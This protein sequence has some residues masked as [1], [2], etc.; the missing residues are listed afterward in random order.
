M[1]TGTTRICGIMADPVEHSMSPVM[2]NFYGKV[3]GKDFAYIPMK[4]KEEQVEAAIKG[5]YAMNFLG[6]NVTV[7]HKQ[8][9]IKY[10]KEIDKT[11]EMIG[12]VNTLVRTDGGF[13]G[14]NADAAGLYRSMEEKGFPLEGASCI[15][16]GAGGAARAAACVFMEHGAGEVFI[17]NRNRTRG[18]ELA[19]DMN[20]LAGRKVFTA[21]GL[22]DYGKIPEGKYICIQSTSVGMHPHD[23]EALIEDKSFYDKISYGMDVVYTP[24]ETRFMKLVRHGGGQAYNGLDMLVYQGIIAYELWNPDVKIGPEAV[25][26][27]RRLLICQL[28]GNRP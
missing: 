26:E 25:N 20:R 10:L 7:P 28:E 9:V 23:E 12:A 6:M 5:A 18:E 19:A 1:I 2:Q 27:A 4:V 8:H 3:T 21:M 14:Y 11:A 24:L 16:L 22:S 17:L 15:L 13:K